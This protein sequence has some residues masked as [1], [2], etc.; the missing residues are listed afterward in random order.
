MQMA[1]GELLPDLK[2]E[3]T[4]RLATDCRNGTWYDAPLFLERENDWSREAGF[5]QEECRR[6]VSPFPRL[7]RPTFASLALIDVEVAQVAHVD[8]R[9]RGLAG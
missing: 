7:Y 3:V 9:Q 5:P 8:A 6:L 1:R 4:S 2:A